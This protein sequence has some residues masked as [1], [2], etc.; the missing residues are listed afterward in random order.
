MNQYQIFLDE[1]M[2][3]IKEDVARQDRYL[4]EGRRNYQ[5][6]LDR[7]GHL[8]A[9]AAKYLY[10]N[11]GHARARVAKLVFEGVRQMLSERGLN[12]VLQV[13][14]TPSQGAVAEAAAIGFDPEPMKRLIG[15]YFGEINML[16]I[17]EP[18]FY[19]RIK[20]GSVVGLVCFHLHGLAWGDSPVR[21]RK[22]VE[23]F[24]NPTQNSMSNC[25]ALRCAL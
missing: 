5:R 16:G 20:M 11:N 13:T 3:E 7:H 2:D 21:V 9:G 14:L 10:A 19:P 17:I 1:L 23:P 22:M 8:S 4:K 18:G 12:S 6:S 24:K 15:K 25:N